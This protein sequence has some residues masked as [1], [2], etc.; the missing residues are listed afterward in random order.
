MSALR[1]FLT[2]FVFYFRSHIYSGTAISKAFATAA[3]NFAEAY[4]SYIALKNHRKIRSVG[5]TLSKKRTKP[6]KALAISDFICY[7]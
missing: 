2:L 1:S 7:T 4:A 6:K 3:A 5:A